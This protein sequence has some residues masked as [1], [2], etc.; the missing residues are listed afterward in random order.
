MF[1][2]VEEAYAVLKDPQER[3]WYDDH[4]E[5][6]L[7]GVDPESKESGDNLNL[8]SY[9]STSCFDDFEDEENGFFQVYD[10]VFRNIDNIERLIDTDPEPSPS[11]GCS[12]DEWDIVSRF[13]SYWKS[14]R[15][16][17][18]FA[19]VDEYKAQKSDKRRVRRL[20]EAENRKKRNEK[21]REYNDLVRRLVSYVRKRDPRVAE[22]DT[23]MLKLRQE[24]EQLEKETKER[25]AKLALERQKQAREAEKIRLQKLYDENP[26]LFDEVEVSQFECVL[27]NKIF[28]SDKAYAN[29]ENSKKHKK[30]AKKLQYQLRKEEELAAKRLGNEKKIDDTAENED[31]L[32][33]NLESPVK[34]DTNTDEKEITEIEDE[35]EVESEKIEYKCVCCDKTFSTENQLQSHEKSKNTK[36]Y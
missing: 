32:D 11:F 16:T 22:H 30:A 29:H 10:N 18:K 6:I 2:Q 27:C 31:E 20:I 25:E 5:Q 7:L 34:T 23:K 9:F 8:W 4:R 21:R 35:E 26:E 14:F 24:R 3:A 28:K 13:Y 19:W 17:R 36:K 33:D 1:K 12:I 15:S